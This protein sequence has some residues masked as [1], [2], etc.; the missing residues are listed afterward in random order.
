MTTV[1][2][3][4]FSGLPTSSLGYTKYT[5]ET[6][7]IYLYDTNLKRIVVKNENKNNLITQA[8]NVKTD[9]FTTVSRNFNE[10]YNIEFEELDVLD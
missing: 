8:I 5:V 9:T 2:E 1:G 4:S 6:E 3:K 10:L 7:E